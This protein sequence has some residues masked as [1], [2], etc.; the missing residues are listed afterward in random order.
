MRDQ[1][2]QEGNTAQVYDL[3]VAIR[4]SKAAQTTHLMRRAGLA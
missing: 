2:A 3:S 1:A 4:R